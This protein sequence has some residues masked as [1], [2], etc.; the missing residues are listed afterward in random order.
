MLSPAKTVREKKIFDLLAPIAES[1]ALRLVR[2]RWI[3]GAE[4]TLQCMLERAD[5]TSVSLDDCQRF[6]QLASPLL[7]VHDAIAEHYDLEMSSTGID[8]PLT[9]HE[10][11][12]RFVGSVIRMTF[13]I[14]VY[15]RKRAIG[16]I[17]QVSASHCSIKLA[18]E[19]HDTLEIPLEAFDT[20]QIVITDELLEAHGFGSF[21]KS[22]KNPCSLPSK[23]RKKSHSPGRSHPGSRREEKN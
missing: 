12:Q 8:R 11:L 9:S 22:A 20:A 19:P 21:A 16:T 23:N 17:L 3:E 10:D 7:D 13:V 1:E 15:Q 6:S 2:V 4:S 5:H 18:K 14:P